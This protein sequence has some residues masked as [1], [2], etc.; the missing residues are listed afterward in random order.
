MDFL[1]L[2]NE[3]LFQTL[4][5]VPG[6]QLSEVC[7]TDS[8]TRAV[9]SDSSF[10]KRKFEL[11]GLPLLLEGESYFGWIRIYE[12]AKFSKDYAN[13]FVQRYSGNFNL[14]DEDSG[15]F[16]FPFLQIYLEDIKDPNIL[17]LGNAVRSKIVEFLTQAWRFSFQEGMRKDFVEAKLHTPEID[18]SNFPFFEV[19]T[20][21]SVERARLTTCK[22]WRKRQ[23]GQYEVALQIQSQEE[24]TRWR[25]ENYVYEISLDDLWNL[26]YR[27]SFFGIPVRENF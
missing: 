27:L 22:I 12:L 7:V 16:F 24:N 14:T 23:I 11:E 5:E 18:A 17:L 26:V 9:C 21:G 6:E 20:F 1:S 19:R 3:I 8:R 13:D 2:P 10:W 4:L 25:T 15:V